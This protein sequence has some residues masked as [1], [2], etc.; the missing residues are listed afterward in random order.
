MY[1]IWK[2]LSPA[3]QL[4]ALSSNSDIYLLSRTNKRNIIDIEIGKNTQLYQF[5]KASLVTYV[6]VYQIIALK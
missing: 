3:K 1:P 4:K 5:A 6:T 2:I